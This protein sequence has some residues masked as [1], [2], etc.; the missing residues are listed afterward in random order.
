MII[1]PYFPD[2]V[3]RDGRA[4]VILRYKGEEY[5]RKSRQVKEEGEAEVL[6]DGTTISK[7]IYITEYY[8]I[9]LEEERAI[10]Q[11]ESESKNPKRE[12]SE[13]IIRKALTFDHNKVYRKSIPPV[14]VKVNGIGYVRRDRAVKTG[15]EEVLEDGTTVSKT[16]YITE[17]YYVPE[18]EV[19]GEQPEYG[20][21]STTVSGQN[22]SSVN[23]ANGGDPLSIEK[24][25]TNISSDGGNPLKLPNLD[26][27]AEEFNLLRKGHI[28]GKPKTLK[29]ISGD[30]SN[31]RFDVKGGDQSTI[32]LSVYYTD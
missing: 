12:S 2:R 22:D 28:N 5:Y 9:P 3:Y 32:A 24:A 8:Y 15:E 19:K 20:I 11:A 21:V 31:V 13:E 30:D 18:M 29:F 27:S 25:T 14:Y 7:T 26:T 16:N 6:E 4:P 23:E 1:R 17:Y 10:R